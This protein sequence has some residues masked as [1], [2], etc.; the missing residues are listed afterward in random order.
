M[1]ATAAGSGVSSSTR[2]GGRRS[3]AGA[4]SS[5]AKAQDIRNALK[6]LEQPVDG[7]AAGGGGESRQQRRSAW[8]DDIDRMLSVDG[9][10]GVGQLTADR[11]AALNHSGNS[12]SSASAGVAAGRGRMDSWLTGVQLQQP[13]HHHGQQPQEVQRQTATAVAAATAVLETPRA[14]AISRQLDEAME[15]ATSQ[16]SLLYSCFGH[17]YCK[18]QF[19]YLCGTWV[20]IF[21][22]KWSVQLAFPS[23]FRSR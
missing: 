18:R 4:S 19:W 22:L 5:S 2:D 17:R 21:R 13:Q 12:S 6:A 11:L 20:L 1:S 8:V 23:E 3:A 15:A 10:S 14:E 16:V 9:G 7:R